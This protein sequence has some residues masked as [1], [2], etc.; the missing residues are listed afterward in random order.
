MEACPEVLVNRVGTLDAVIARMVTEAF[1]RV[2][3]APSQRPQV[4]LTPPHPPDTLQPDTEAS[5]PTQ[6]LPCTQHPE[7]Y[8]MDQ[9]P[10]PVQA[11]Q[12][13]VQAVSSAGASSSSGACPQAGFRPRKRLRHSCDLLL[14]AAAG[15]WAAVPTGWHRRSHRV[16]AATAGD[17][18]WAPDQCEAAV[19]AALHIT[20]QAL[21][22]SL[23][24]FLEPESFGR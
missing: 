1:P 18:F 10:L 14:Q 5:E 9:R 4:S 15:A 8:V 6:L 2:Q 3:G 24:V 16:L 19:A 21:V 17:D 12:T 22:C 13:P 7:R 11:L 23:V 20:G